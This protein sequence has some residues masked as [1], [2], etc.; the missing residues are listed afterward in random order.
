MQIIRTGRPKKLNWIFQCLNL[1]ARR[2]SKT[3]MKLGTK[4]GTKLEAFELARR[5]LTREDSG[6]F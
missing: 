6:G 3:T 5:G 4:L 2:T 1:D